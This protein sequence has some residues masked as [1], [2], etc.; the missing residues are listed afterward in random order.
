MG[1]LK[2]LKSGMWETLKLCFLLDENDEILQ[3]WV[4]ADAFGNTILAYSGLKPSLSFT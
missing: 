1:W 4:L 2:K 3:D